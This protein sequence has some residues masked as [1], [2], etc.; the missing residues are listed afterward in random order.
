MSYRY[1]RPHPSITGYVRTVL[2]LQGV[3]DRK[4]SDLPFFT[5]GMPALFCRV[6]NGAVSQLTLFGQTVPAEQWTTAENT[7]IIA[8]FFKPFA[9]GT[10]F[11]IAARDMKE[12]PVELCRWN[13]RKNIALGMQLHHATGM[14][15][16]IDVLD[17]L[18]IKQ[19][20]HNIKDCTIVRYA[21]D[22]MMRHPDTDVLSRLLTELNVTERTFQRIFKKYVGVTPNQYRRICQFYFAFTQLKDRQFEKLADIAYTN[23][24]FD[25]SHYIRSFKEFT[26]TTPN[27]YIRNGLSKKDE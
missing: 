9:L 19:I 20:E 6:E 12:N 13:A 25:Q 10:I 24:Y 27:D 21:T 4:A 5:N 11:G 7:A 18:I 17:H 22:E 8:Y 2:I 23:G 16:K 15:E 14:E 1:Q 26:D 3:F